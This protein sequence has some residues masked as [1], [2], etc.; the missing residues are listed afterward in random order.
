MI[1]LKIRG[2]TI[3]YCSKLKKKR[4]ILEHELEC[5]IRD[6]EDKLLSQQNSIKTDT[7]LEI[8]KCKEDFKEI[9]QTALQGIIL[10]SKAN[11]YELNEKPTKLICNLEKKNY[12]NKTICKINTGQNI[13]TEPRSILKELKRFYM[14]LYKSSRPTTAK[15]ENQFFEC[16]LESLRSNR[17]TIM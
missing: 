15:T 3:S 10:R 16:K 6:L 17:K 8:Q 12:V 13:L 7:V 2:V 9:Q 5:K 1:K 4:N 14:N 11:L